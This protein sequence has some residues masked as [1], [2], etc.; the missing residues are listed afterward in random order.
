MTG[1]G[2][3]AKGGDQEVSA[4]LRGFTAEGVELVVRRGAKTELERIPMTAS[5]DSAHF[6]LRLFDLVE[7]TEYYVESNGVRSALFTIDIANLPFVKKIDLEYRY[8]GYTGM[9]SE[10]VQDGG[11]I[12]APRGT[13]VIVHAT[14]TMPVKGGRL[15]I[16]GKPPVAM[17][18]NADGT[19]TAP[20]QVTANGFCKLELHA[21]NDQLVPGSL[22]YTIDVL[23][24]RPPTIKFEKP[25]RD[26]KVSAIEEVFTQVQ[27]TD[28]YGVT[29]ID[30]LYSVN[31]Q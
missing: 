3:V 14:P 13:T 6:S 10:T 15:T 7:K 23:D 19:L 17:T 20:I 2:T 5:G 30:L 16:E 24:D 27:A 25:G 28:D 22:D 11:D 12:A 1:N 9:A 21:A 8:P 18:L 26:T 31:G 29:N 4:T